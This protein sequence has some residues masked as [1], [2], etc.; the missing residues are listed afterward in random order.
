MRELNTIIKIDLESQSFS[1]V[2]QPYYSKLI[3]G[4][5]V[6]THL[7]SEFIRERGNAVNYFSILSGPF[8]GVYPYA[9]KGYFTTLNNGEYNSYIGGGSIAS[10]L[11][12]NNILGI[13]VYG[14]SEFPV[15]IEISSRVVKFLNPETNP[16]DSLG[17]A[18]KKS[19]L[20]FV[21][22]IFNDNYF[23][24]S[25]T[26]TIAKE[27]GIYGLVFSAFSDFRIPDYQ[28]Y[29]EVYNSIISKEDQ[30]TVTKGSNPSCFGCPMGCAFS[31]VPEKNNS[32]I[33]PR[34]LISC[35]YANPIYSDIN[36]VFSCF[37]AIGMSYNHEFLESFP[38]TASRIKIDLDSKV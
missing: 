34:S 6:A 1:F 33:L 8:C 21:G 26:S 2:S 7:L 30:L 9:S 4:E 3:G 38:N 22:K 10:Y 23:L 32:S 24:Y 15:N 16:L 14:Q 20:S 13:E 29:K 19:T 12:L 27:M 37:N 17:T 5:V 31:N 35:I 18:G 25:D 36:T 28:N 11:N